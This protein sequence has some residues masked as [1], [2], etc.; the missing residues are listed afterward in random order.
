MKAFCRSCQENTLET[1]LDL[2][3][4]P[5]ADRILSHEELGLPEP[6]FPLE[7]AFCHNCSLVQILETVSPDE[8]FC[9]NYPY[10]SSVSSSLLE[11]SKKNVL[12]LIESRNLNSNSF[13]VE[14]ASNDGYLLK[15]YVENGIQ[16][17]GIDPAEGPAKAAEKIGVPTKCTF[18]TES[19]A[20]KMADDGERADVIHANNVLAHVADTNGFVEGIRTLLKDEGVAVFEVPYVKDLVDNCEFD[21]IYH[22]HLCYF[23]VTSLDYLF[24]RHGLFLNKVRHLSIHGGSLRLYVEPRELVGESV[25]SFLEDEH[26]NKIDCFSYYSEFAGKVFAVKDSLGGLLYKLKSKGSKIAAYGAAAKGCT[27]MNYIGID[28]ELVDFIVD[29]NPYKQGKF[30]TGMHQPIYAPER[31]MDEMP[32]YVLLLPWNFADEILQQQTCY[33]Q[34]GGKFIIPIPEPKIV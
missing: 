9:N 10:Y 14:L 3:Y 20:R 1:F 2:G 29:K 8:L 26:R 28:K 6:S 15:N 34:K 5:L 32:D 11:H 25:K 21:T 18:F 13:V 12:E 17:V 30:M 33:R 24:R 23:S 7:V 4:S 22:Q 27:L 31:L 19:L 16:C